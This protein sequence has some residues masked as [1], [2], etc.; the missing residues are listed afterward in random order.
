VPPTDD[1]RP[2]QSVAAQISTVVVRIVHEYTGRGPT[3]ARTTMHDGLVTVVLGETLLK[4][5]NRLIADGQSDLVL[6]M[7]RRFQQGMEDDLSAAVSR[8]TKRRV[9]AFMSANHLDP[10]L[11]VEVFVLE[12]EPSDAIDA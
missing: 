9:I 3:K 7:R 1:Q 5:E 6:E 2:G 4:A 11:M 10:D 8:L 12:P